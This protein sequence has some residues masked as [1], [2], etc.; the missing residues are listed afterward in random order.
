MTKRFLLLVIISVLYFSKVS[1]QE[2]YG[3][4]LGNE[5][6]AWVEKVYVG[7]GLGGLTWSQ[8]Y[9]SA[10][11]YGMVGYRFTDKL[12]S[13]VGI[14]YQYFN[15][16]VFNYSINN[17]GFNFFT[18]YQVY[19]PFFLMAQYEIYFIEQFEG[20]RRQMDALLLGGGVSQPLGGKG[21]KIGRA[22]V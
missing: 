18:Q 10:S 12:N 19:D 2:N 9:F 21:F 5:K 1:A 11:L 8:D 4:V 3:D 14:N 15:D 20:G 7:G 16:K 13:G 6:P 17:Y 22:H